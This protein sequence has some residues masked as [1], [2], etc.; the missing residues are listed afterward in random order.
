MSGQKTPGRG[1][2][3]MRILTFLPK[4]LE[5]SQKGVYLHQRKSQKGVKY[6]R[7]KSQKGANDI[8]M[9]RKNYVE[10]GIIKTRIH[11]PLP[12]SKEL[13]GIAVAQPVR[14]LPF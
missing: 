12:Y 2:K 7:A 9:K 13:N 8:V 11:Q 14:N 1:E 4:S 6:G 5:K 10:F 3:T